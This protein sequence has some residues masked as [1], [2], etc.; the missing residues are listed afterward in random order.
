MREIV[1]V[2]FLP[3]WCM[4]VVASLPRYSVKISQH[5]VWSSPCVHTACRDS[6]CALPEVTTILGQS[7]WP[8]LIVC[9]TARTGNFSFALASL[10]IN[11]MH[12]AQYFHGRVKIDEDCFSR[13]SCWGCLSTFSRNDHGSH[14]AGRRPNQLHT[15]RIFEA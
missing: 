8:S 7:L 2:W 3:R 10:G 4:N 6:T 5:P 14:A 15:R 13:G 1:W 12:I 11:R 9:T